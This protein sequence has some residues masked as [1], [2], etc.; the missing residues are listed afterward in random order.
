MFMGWIGVARLLARLKPYWDRFW[1]ARRNCANA[2]YWQKQRRYF[3]WRSM[4]QTVPICLAPATLKPCAPQHRT[5]R[6]LSDP[7]TRHAHPPRRNSRRAGWS[8]R[9]RANKRRRR[10]ELHTRAS[11][12]AGRPF[13]S[14]AGCPAMRIFAGKS[15]HVARRQSGFVHGNRHGAAGMVA[16]GRRRADERHR[17]ASPLYMKPAT[18]WRRAKTPTAQGLRWLLCWPTPPGP[19]RLSAAKRLR[20]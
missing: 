9:R 10:F 20:A 15:C 13:E 8:C 6:P 2:W 7:P 17:F 19:S 14:A 16:A 5:Y 12:R 3:T 4:S 18:G 11:A 1:H